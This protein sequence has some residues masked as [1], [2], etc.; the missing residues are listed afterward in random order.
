M[1]LT[2]AA[3]ENFEDTEGW[4]A[5]GCLSNLTLQTKNYVYQYNAASN[6]DWSGEIPNLSYEASIPSSST[7]N[8]CEMKKFYH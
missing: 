5:H 8:C 2:N 1:S 6:V 4:F 3:P 7:S